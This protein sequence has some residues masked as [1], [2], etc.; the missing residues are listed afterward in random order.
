LGH[1]GS[2][3]GARAA[4]NFRHAIRVFANQLAFGLRAVGFVALPVA[5]GLFTN[6]L[7][8][9]LRSLAMSYAVGLL[10]NCDAFRAVEHFATFVGALNFTFGF[11]AFYITNSILRFST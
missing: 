3:H 8:F 11:L 5:S 6:W 1:S 4:L 2:S 10:A 9:G 7:A